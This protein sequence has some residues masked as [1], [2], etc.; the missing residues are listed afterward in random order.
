MALFICM[1][2]C[3]RGVGGCLCRPEAN[4]RGL[5]LFFPY[6]LMQ[7]LTLSPDLTNLEGQSAIKSWVIGTHRCSWDSSTV[8]DDYT[9]NTNQPSHLPSPS[10][11]NL[12]NVESL[13]NKWGWCFSSVIFMGQKCRACELHF[14][15]VQLPPN[16]KPK[17]F[18]NHLPTPSR[19]ISHY[20][21]TPSQL[22]SLTS[23]GTPRCAG[24]W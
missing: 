22:P 11:C 21:P 24:S 14:Q 3:V 19:S 23:H 4:I 17:P 9:R 12:F 8:P 7:A 6:L 1:C 16:S 20:Y 2:S 10:I 5:P 15:L 18:P 13:R